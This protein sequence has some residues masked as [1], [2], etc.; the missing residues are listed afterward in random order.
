M[1]KAIVG[2]VFV[3]VVALMVMS[4]ATSV[5]AQQSNPGS[6]RAI[7]A[8]GAEADGAAPNFDEAVEVFLSDSS[9]PFVLRLS[10]DEWADGLGAVERIVQ[11]MPMA[12]RK[13]QQVQPMLKTGPVAASLSLLGIDCREHCVEAVDLEGD[14][15]MTADILDDQAAVRA[16]RVGLAWLPEEDFPSAVRV[17]ILLPA[18]NVST[19]MEILERDLVAPGFA[20]A[21]VTPRRSYLEVELLITH[22]PLDEELLASARQSDR[23]VEPRLTPALEHFSNGQGPVV[24][25]FR[26]GEFQR[27]LSGLE[28]IEGG[29]A[30]TKS[31]PENRRRFQAR[32]AQALL[33]L[34]ALTPVDQREVEDMSLVVGATEAGGL[35]A[36]WVATRT[37]FG[38][39]LADTAP[40]KVM[41]AGFSQEHLPAED[42]IVDL[43]WRVPMDF[44]DPLAL[45]PVEG[46]TDGLVDLLHDIAGNTGIAPV[47]PSLYNPNYFLRM[48][49]SSLDQELRGMVPLAFR[50]RLGEG[51]ELVRGALVVRFGADAAVVGSLLGLVGAQAAELEAMGL[52]HEVRELDG[53]GSELV[54]ALGIPT[55]DAVGEREQAPAAQH[56][57]VDIAAAQ[58]ILTHIAPGL[59]FETQLP[60]QLHL[61]GDNA[62]GVVSWTMT[63]GD[64]AAEV[65]LAPA[66]M[67]LLEAEE[68]G[69]ERDVFV[70]GG[71]LLERLERLGPS[72]NLSEIIDPFDEIADACAARSAEL[73]EDLMWAKGRARWVVSSI[74][75]DAV[76]QYGK[77]L[78]L[79]RREQDQ[80][81]CAFT[82]TYDPK[83]MV[84]DLRATARLLE[85]ACTFGDAAS[86]QERRE[87]PAEES[88]R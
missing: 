26:T 78:D 79:C 58:R 68:A 39:K 4:S 72:G 19:A 47:G 42:A 46:G 30:I 71:E 77:Y 66:Q 1:R 70:A 85:Q 40:D 8:S 84:L 25:Y 60:D 57:R 33:N 15:W 9:T 75:V 45:V 20:K 5:L 37:S 81:A 13:T 69:C 67:P 38:Q 18:H 86:C 43:S 3:V 48:L 51:G 12:P 35:V 34:H 53:G 44:E 24:V 31:T 29:Q 41:I 21:Q 6:D 61:M 56:F 62:E 49:V 50:L 54:V 82:E 59:L 73:R 28:A 27:F 7:G 88:L 10:A 52:T 74:F 23:P 14:L 22:R 11:A 17:R 2:G 76:E 63:L 55:D 65:A 87:L 36:R 16:T 32:G 80:R 83:Q 64:S